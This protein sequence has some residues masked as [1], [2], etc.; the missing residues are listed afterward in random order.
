MKKQ[1]SILKAWE[2]Y[3]LHLIGFFLYN[4]LKKQELKM[5]EFIDRNGYK[6]QFLPEPNQFSENAKHVLVICEYNQQWLL[7]NHKERGWEFPGGKVEE[8]E[9]LHA[10]ARREVLEE[11]G[12]IIRELVPFGA[13]KVNEPNGYFIK[14]IFYATIDKIKPKQGY[15]ETNGPVLVEKDL[16]LTDRFNSHYSFIMQDQIVKIVLEEMAKKQKMHH[17]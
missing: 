8:N 5:N 6:V 4:S 14:K 7:T 3:E 15:Y 16:L 17:S 11:T 12:A 9:T 2:S 1:K 10:A 13:Y